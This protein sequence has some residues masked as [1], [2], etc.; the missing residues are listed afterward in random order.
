MFLT[1]SYL[2]YHDDLILADV[3]I[4]KF[5]LFCASSLYVEI[6]YVLPIVNRGSDSII[7][8]NISNYNFIIY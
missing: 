8:C 2:L 4:F 6:G 5:I 1:T 3:V 7:I